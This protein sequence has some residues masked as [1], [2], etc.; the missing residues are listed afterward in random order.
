MFRNKIL[1]DEIDKTLKICFDCKKLSSKKLLS[2][3]KNI[4]SILAIAYNNYKKLDSKY[5]KGEIIDKIINNKADLVDFDDYIEMIENKPN[6]S[7]YMFLKL[8]VDMAK[9]EYTLFDGSKKDCRYDEIMEKAETFNKIFQKGRSLAGCYDCGTIGRAIFMTFIKMKNNCYKIS[10]KLEKKMVN[11]SCKMFDT[12]NYNINDISN[13]YSFEDKDI[14]L[15]RARDFKNELSKDDEHNIYICSISLSDGIGHIWIFEKLPN[16]E[17]RLYQS[18]LNEFLLIDFLK[19]MNYNG[20]NNLQIKDINK[21][22]KNLKDLINLKEWN[23]DI[24]NKY[25]DLFYHYPNIKNGT[26]FKFKFMYSGLY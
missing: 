14:S 26:K 12:S 1:L 25:Y 7:T 21:F 24:K 4:R 18:S 9:D 22:I 2:K 11:D 17:Y 6:T 20:N 8:L 3:S 23:D 13:N 16:L 10:K 19:Y 5:Q 15:K